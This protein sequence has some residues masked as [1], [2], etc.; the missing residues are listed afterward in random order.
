MAEGRQRASRRDSHGSINQEQGRIDAG[1]AHEQ[2]DDREE[3]DRGSDRHRQH[4]GPREVRQDQWDEIEHPY[5]DAERRIR[6]RDE[7]RAIDS[8]IAAVTIGLGACWNRIMRGSAALSWQSV[9]LGTGLRQ[10]LP[11]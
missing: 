11:C 4:R 8:P 5:G 7:D 2:T 6:I 10:P 3:D 1:R 9:W